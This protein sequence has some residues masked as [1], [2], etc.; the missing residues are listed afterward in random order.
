MAGKKEPGKHPGGRPTDYREEY[1]ELAYKFCLLGAEDKDLAKMFDVDESTINNWKKVYPEFFESI[2]KGK[3]IADANV[4]DRLYQRAMGYT[5][6]EL[7]TAT[8]QGKI[9]DKLIVD[10][11][12]PPEPAAAIFWLKNRQRGRWKD[13]IEQELSTPPGQPFEVKNDLS[14][15]ST[16]LL[17]QLQREMEG[18]K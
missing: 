7:V 18:K 10:K 6:P 3:D 16:E 11:H 2:K 13:K 9:T 1:N 12:Y 15:V 5:H 4:A 17:L 8:F 14:G